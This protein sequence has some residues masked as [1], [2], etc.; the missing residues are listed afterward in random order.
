MAVALVPNETVVAYLSFR[1]VDWTTDQWFVD[2]VE[3]VG[4][5]IDVKV[6]HPFGDRHIIG[7]FTA[8]ALSRRV[9][10][11]HH[12]LLGFDHNLAQ[13]SITTR[14]RLTLISVN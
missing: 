13:N 9:G 3:A 7:V 8:L 12:R 2:I 10:Q 11:S 14:I 5:G 4:H 6:I 1:F